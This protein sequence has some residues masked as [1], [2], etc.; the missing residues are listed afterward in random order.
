MR[1]YYALYIV[2]INIVL[3]ISVLLSLKWNEVLESRK[4]FK[5]V[6]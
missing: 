3:R 2:E 6:K 1:D 5:D 4:K